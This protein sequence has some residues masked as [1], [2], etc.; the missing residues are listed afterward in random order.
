MEETMK[1]NYKLSRSIDKFE[2]S[3]AS[4]IFEKILSKPE[5]EQDAVRIVRNS[6][7]DGYTVYGKSICDLI[8]INYEKAD[9]DAYNTLINEIYS[10]TDIA[11]LKDTVS[12]YTYLEMT[13][14]NNSI[15]LADDQKAFAVSEAMGQDGTEKRFIDNKLNELFEIFD[16]N[17]INILTLNE[18]EKLLKRNDTNNHSN[19]PYDIRY[20]ILRNNNWTDE[21]KKKLLKNFWRD[22]NEYAIILNTWVE[23]LI[24]NLDAKEEENVDL[25][26]DELYFLK[27]MRTLRKPKMLEKSKIKELRS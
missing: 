3:D 25:V 4:E 1:I 12:N 24:D 13:L 7:N 16:E 27:R 2:V 18:A 9:K 17:K 5:M 8:L 11:R 15:R 23:D 6:K 22:E 21:E 19:N 26:L 10:N 14:K 20:C